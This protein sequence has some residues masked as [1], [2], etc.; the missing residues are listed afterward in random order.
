MNN[1]DR[2]YLNVLEET[3]QENVLVKSD[4]FYLKVTE[5]VEG[6]YLYNI[7]DRVIY[8]E[9]DS[10]HF[11][12][13]L[14]GK[15][16][17]QVLG[18]SMEGVTTGQRY[19]ITFETDQDGQLVMKYRYADKDILETFVSEVRVLSE[20]SKDRTYL[21]TATGD[22]LKPLMGGNTLNVVI[23]DCEDKKSYTC[24]FSY[25][26]KNYS[27]F[28][29]LTTDI[30]KNNSFM[31]ITDYF[32]KVIAYV[33]IDDL[34]QP[35]NK[36]QKVEPSDE[37]NNLPKIEDVRKKTDESLHITISKIASLIIK[38]SEAG[39][40]SVLVPKGEFPDSSRRRLLDEIGKEGYRVYLTAIGDLVVGW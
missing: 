39:D 15:F 2:V 19:V 14:K 9:L 35:H 21:T 25:K 7:Y 10:K 37:L 27:Y 4:P 12:L 5:G 1:F 22:I 31:R 26:H 28:K 18:T 38:A 13:L 24:Q 23:G 36:K 30:V 20:V 34:F 40:S 3:A 16:E 8:I 33:H 17:T 32:G 11:G 29:V 6:V